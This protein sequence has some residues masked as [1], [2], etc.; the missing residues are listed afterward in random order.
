MAACV[1]AYTLAWLP[2]NLYIVAAD[3][4]G[5]LD[6]LSED[7]HIVLF[8]VVHCLAMSHTCYNPV[9]YFWMNGQFRQAYCRVLP[10]LRS[11]PFGASYSE[12]VSSRQITSKH[13]PH[14]YQ[15]S[16]V[17]EGSCRGTT[18]HLQVL[19]SDDGRKARYHQHNHHQDETKTSTTATSTTTSTHH[20][21]QMGFL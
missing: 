13:D 19:V 4:P 14:V 16:E 8:F 7:V 10:C 21:H 3:V 9:I 5:L 1:V 20:P 6:L 11:L 15:G 12:G 18:I 2:L 17:P